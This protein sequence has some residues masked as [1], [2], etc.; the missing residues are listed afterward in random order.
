MRVKYM[1]MQQHFYMDFFR[2]K[3]QIYMSTQL[4]RTL[5][6]FL[7]CHRSAVYVFKKNLNEFCLQDHELECGGSSFHFDAVQNFVKCQ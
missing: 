4:T 1:H 6:D 5:K 7:A 3:S 2:N